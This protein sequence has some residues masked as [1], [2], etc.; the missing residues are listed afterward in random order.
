VPGGTYLRGYDGI[1]FV[2]DGH[3]ATVTDFRLDRY[4]VTVGR[5]RAFVEAGGGVQTSLPAT[6]DGAK[7]GIYDSGW[8][9]DWKGFVL[10]RTASLV[11]ELHCH[12]DATWTDAPGENEHLPIVC[13]D[14]FEAMLF[15][16]WDGG[17][18]PTETEYA[19]AQ[20]GGDEQRYYPWSK[21]P[22]LDATHAVYPPSPILAVGMRPAGA[23]RWNQ[24]DL[25][26]NAWMW[27][28]DFVV[29]GWPRVCVDCFW[30]GFEGERRIRGGSWIDPVGYLR[31][32][33]RHPGTADRTRWRDLGVRCAREP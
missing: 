21:Q 2:D 26:G 22:L 9:H 32:A 3:P 13:V 18:L 5:F 25:A 16:I 1:D 15:C 24:L 10:P 30:G 8:H 17:R 29:D 11:T 12:D 19:Y 20:S 4:P 7:P 6:R 14:W 28:Y 33:A 31:S 23:G 27:M